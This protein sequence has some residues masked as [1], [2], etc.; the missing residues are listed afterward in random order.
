MPK[1][2][3][4]MRKIREVLR[5]HHE[6]GLSTRQ[7]ARAVGLAKSSVLDYVHRARA[8]G[9]Q[10]PLPAKMDDMALE[11]LLFPNK[12]SEVKQAQ[13]RKTLNFSYLDQQMKRKNVTLILL[14]EEYKR[15]Y[16]GG[17]QYSRFR[18][19]Y[20]KW[21]KQVDLP[22]RQEH[23]VGEKLFIDYCGETMAYRDEL[24]QIKK[25][26]IFVAVLG[27][28]NYTFA[29]ATP[30]QGLPDWLDAHVQAF[31]FFGGVPEILV[32]DNLKS[33][34]N[35]ACPYE[36][37]LNASYLE[38]ARHYQVAVIPARVRKP[39]DKA[40]AEIGVQLVQRWI[41]A[42]LRDRPTLSL[43]QLNREI[44]RRIQQLNEKS[45]KKLPGNRLQ[46]FQELDQPALKPLPDH[47]YEYAQWQR[48]RVG[49]DYHVE[50]EGHYYSVPHT[51]AGYLVDVRFN[52][53]TAEVFS[54]QSR[55]A[56][57]PRD[58]GPGQTTIREHM[59]ENHR[60][61]AGWNERELM[62]WAQETGPQTHAAFK[63][64]MV[65]P[66]RVYHQRIR[67]CVGLMNLARGFGTHRLE[68]ACRRA[69]Q[70]QALTY[71]S[72]QSILKNG[73]DQQPLDAGVQE[74]P[75]LD[76]NNIRG[77]HYYT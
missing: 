48:Q 39:K 1:A 77:A 10:W 32:P 23:K 44:A 53:K 22:M 50:L 38:L 52:A 60:Q 2:R 36:P 18:E 74:R 68:A 54:R 41:C 42:S 66:E 17:Y 24:G 59:P 61:Y 63:A 64:V 20:R 29:C 67:C 26:A 13:R 30:S 45:F 71:R 76:H 57:H 58:M 34:V 37:E 8:V 40:K 19:L 35:R 62:A 56:V 15:Q 12:S 14:W 21:K 11:E 47:S 7:V 73:L 27:A 72:I 31:S 49:R 75:P 65:D 16:P 69:L 33:G 4:P 70:V 51:Y 25:A 9:L 28:S 3:L 6:C 55:I 43:D 5:L 46:R